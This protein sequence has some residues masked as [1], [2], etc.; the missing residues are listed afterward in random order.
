[1]IPVQDLFRTNYYK[2][3][4]YYGSIDGT[5]FRIAMV[6]PEEGDAFFEVITW[7]GPYNFEKTPEEQKESRRF[8]FEDASMEEIAAYVNSFARG[9][10]AE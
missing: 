9:E 1:M 5:N 8:P 7:P 6:K 3:K 2:K 10:A 4:P